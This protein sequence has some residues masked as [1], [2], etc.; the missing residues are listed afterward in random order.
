MSSRP[1]LAKT[2]GSVKR[3]GPRSPQVFTIGYA[4]RTPETLIDRV[5]SFGG[6]AIVDVRELPLSRRPG[7]SKIAL[8]GA[9]LAAGLD[10]QH[11]RA[12]GNPKPS[13]ALY[14]SGQIQAGVSAYGKHLNNG[15]RPALLALAERVGREQVCL[16]CVEDDPETCHRAVIVEALQKEVADLIVT[17]L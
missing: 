4:T 13:R 9:A 6:T 14:K 11:V 7:F 3:K 12:L 16:L 8:A 10:Y 17:H 1:P 15:S 5:I 2:G